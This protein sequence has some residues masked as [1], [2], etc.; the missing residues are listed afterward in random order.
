[1]T[2]Q[3]RLKEI[4]ELLTTLSIGGEHVYHYWRMRTDPQYVIWAEDGPGE[5]RYADNRHAEQQIHGTID[6]FTIQEFDPVFD[7]IE[8]KL[9][10]ICGSRWEWTSTQ[11]EDETNLIHHEW[12]FFA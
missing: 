12:E 3:E 1:M 9:E 4:H 7:E 2:V 10:Q 5:Y 6:F 11:Y 8:K